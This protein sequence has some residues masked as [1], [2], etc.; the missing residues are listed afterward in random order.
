MQ[1]MKLLKLLAVFLL[2]AMLLPLTVSAYGSGDGTLIIT[3]INTQPSTEGSSIVISG[4][5]ADKVGALGTFNWWAVLIFDWDAEQGCFVLTDHNTNSNN[6]DKSAM[7]I[8]AYGFAYCICI[9]NDYSSDGGINY[10]TDRI[11]NSDTYAKS[12]E[13]GT[14]AYLYGTS[15][16]AGTIKT[17]GK[18]WYESDFVSDSYI[19][20]GTP[21]EGKTAY[22]PIASEGELPQM[23]I[24]TTHV[25]D[26]HYANGDCILFDASFGAY[27]KNTYDYSWWRSIVFDWD[28]AQGYHV[29]IA[30][31]HAA[32][33]GNSKAPVIPENGF[34]LMDCGSASQS[35]V[36]AAVVGMKAYFYK[37]GAQYRICLNVPEEG[38]TPVIPANAEQIQPAPVIEN[39]A[40]DGSTKSTPAEFVVTWKP[41]EGATSYTVSVNLSTP[42]VLGTLVIK[43][44]EV[45]EA[46][47]TIPNMTMAVGNSY[48]VTVRA[49][50]SMSAMARIYCVSEESLDSAL[51]G[52]TILAFGDSLT[53]RSGWVAML[54]GHIGTEVINAGVGG[55]TTIAG[56]ARF[57]KDVLAKQ[58]DIALVC[59]GMNDQAQKTETGKPNVSL[60]EYRENMIHFITELQKIGTDVI[61][62]APH[63]AYAGEGYY[64]PGSYGLDY[65]YGNMADFCRVVRELAVEY[66]CG[67]IDIYAEAQ[68][69]DMTAFLN[70]GD[71][72]HQSPAGHTLWAEYV[73]D[74]LLAK[75]D[76]RNAS[77]VKVLCKD[78]S[79]NELA[80]YSLVAAVGARII[81]PAIE[82]E[83]AAFEGNETCLEVGEDMTVTLTYRASES[84]ES[85]T[86][87]V[88]EPVSEASAAVF[89][90]NDTEPKD[91][92]SPAV[93]AAVIAVVIGVAIVAVVAVVLRKNKK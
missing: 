85:K 93:L 76:G 12:L 54:G 25:N 47:F 48:T 27:V 63:D 6:V 35:N 4:A 24:E 46:S 79:G 89:E 30:V 17:N 67:L 45:T 86:E 34:V 20:I 31:D 32:G 22:D 52:K 7:K 8:P 28:P 39:I 42:T 13:L 10:I 44:T 40:S 2:T 75:Y 74:Y 11:V 33:G 38:K 23:Q 16:Y 36:Q 26:T 90:Q 55:D 49:D 50:N 41:V 18:V 70:A 64:T 91:G 19:K 51:S 58:P 68:Y 1:N 37:E 66:G 59:F 69:E 43:P 9:G 5:Y 84:E 29:V 77:E 82:V 88:S 80:S 73:A 21:D 61:L 57:E 60:E 87:S 92:I 81:F 72:I 78:E 62:I 83:G 65:A 15:L 71:G 3:H 53:A 56:M 14:K